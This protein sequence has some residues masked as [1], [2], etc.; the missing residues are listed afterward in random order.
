MKPIEVARMTGAI[1]LGMLVMV[2][3]TTSQAVSGARH[4]AR[5]LAKRWR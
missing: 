5:K 1:A 3:L 4:G 2:G